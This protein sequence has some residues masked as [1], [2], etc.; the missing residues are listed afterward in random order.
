[1]RATYYKDILEDGLISGGQLLLSTID[2][3]HLIKVARVEVGEPLLL[4]NGRGLKV[5]SVVKKIYKKELLVQI[6][7]WKKFIKPHFL[8]LA[9]CL[10]K[11]SSLLE[12]LRSST[13]IGISSIFPIVSKF[14]QVKTLN[15]ARANKVMESALIQSNNPFFPDL[16]KEDNFFSFIDN[17]EGHNFDHVIYF[18]PTSNLFYK[19]FKI[20]SEEKILFIIGP[21]G[22]PSF[23]EM[24]LLNKKKI[25]FINLPSN[26]LRSQTAVSV[27]AGYLMAKGLSE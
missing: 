26:I 22:G 1:M 5:Y 7:E 4:L 18:S 3:K 27:A 16:Y 21:E 8:N 17:L 19:K 6:A 20:S 12:I 2:V 10:T 25:A 14:S 13:E 24:D 11:Q 23:E 9:I 15:L